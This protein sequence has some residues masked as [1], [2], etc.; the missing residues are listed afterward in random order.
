ML[1][2]CTYSYNYKKKNHWVYI[3]FWKLSEEDFPICKTPMFLFRHNPLK[4][5]ARFKCG[6]KWLCVWNIYN[7]G[8][9][10]CLL[11]HTTSPEAISV[12]SIEDYWK[13]FIHFSIE[14][15]SESHYQIIKTVLPTPIP[16]KPS[17]ILK[18]TSTLVYLDAY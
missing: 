16:Q 15:G 4:T 12:K 5:V 8:K 9:Y 17:G 3:E 13:T 6:M 10:N 18:S 2:L 7:L 1:S 14:E 11:Q